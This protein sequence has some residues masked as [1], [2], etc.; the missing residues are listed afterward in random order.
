MKIANL[1]LAASAV[2]FAPGRLPGTMELTI[3]LLDGSREMVAV[4][5]GPQCSS[6]SGAL[7]MGASLI[8][9]HKHAEEEYKAQ[10]N[11]HQ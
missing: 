2:I 4:L 1:T 5:D 3:M 9:L 10:E 6:L 8:Y 7:A 11:D